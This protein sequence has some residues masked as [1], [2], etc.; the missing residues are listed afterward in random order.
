MIDNFYVGKEE[1]LLKQID[2]QDKKNQLHCE[3]RL[4]VLKNQIT[5]E[6]SEVIRASQEID[7]YNFLHELPRIKNQTLR[8]AEQVCKQIQDEVVRN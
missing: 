6:V 3:Y 4:T 5:K 2:A 1:E 8:N 7:E